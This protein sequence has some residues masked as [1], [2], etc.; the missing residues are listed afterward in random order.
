MGVSVRGV[1]LAAVE[2]S[3][4]DYCRLADRG[5]LVD[6]EVLLQLAERVTVLQP[7]RGKH[8]AQQPTRYRLDLLPPIRVSFAFVAFLEITDERP[9]GG[10]LR[11][12]W[13]PRPG[14]RPT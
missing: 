2:A 7:E 5:R 4:D 6:R 14:H 1:R 9:I 12:G 8:V 13:P 11:A 10:L 3:R